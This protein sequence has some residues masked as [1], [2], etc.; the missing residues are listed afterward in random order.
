MTPVRQRLWNRKTAEITLELTT[1]R[2]FD[3]GVEF[4]D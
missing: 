2:E 3:A 1:R 4:S